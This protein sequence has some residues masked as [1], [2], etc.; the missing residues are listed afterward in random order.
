MMSTVSPELPFEDGS[1]AEIADALGV[2]ARAHGMS[3]L[4]ADTGISRQ[5]LYKALS[6]DGNPGFAMIMKVANALGF[7]LTA[8]RIS[9]R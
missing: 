3:A 7:R 2:V 4:A 6:S 1:P 5:A 9:A 8:E